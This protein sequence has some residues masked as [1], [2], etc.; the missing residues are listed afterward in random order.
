LKVIL[1]SRSSARKE[2]LEKIGFEV[3]QVPAGV[4][5]AKVEVAS[6]EEAVE[7]AVRNAVRKAEMVFEEYPRD[8][9]IAAD[10]LIYLNGRIL[11]KPR[12]FEEAEFF[13]KDMRG[14]WHKV[15]SGYAVYTP[16]GSLSGYE[17]TDVKMR[18]Y[19]D[20][21]IEYYLSSGEFK[22]KAGGYAIQ[23]LGA[24]LVEKVNGCFYNVAGL[25]LAKVVQALL[26]LSY[27]PPR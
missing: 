12:D 24:F 17:I 19:S 5:E 15:V 27:W 14:K 20:R 13:L 8:V 4:D 7:L 22:G 3:I 10:T 18:E 1:A 26:L 23:G 16:R 2:I 6:L 25:P 21:E 9:V 11:G